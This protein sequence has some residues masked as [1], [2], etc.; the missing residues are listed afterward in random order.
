VK[1]PSG[2]AFHYLPLTS[3]DIRRELYVTS[4]GRGRYRPGDPYPIVKHPI[5]YDFAW[6]QGR[7]LSDLAV[8]FL[9]EGG[10]EYEDRTL[11]RI[12]WNAGEVLLLPSGT[13]HRYR[14]DPVRGWTERW[15]CL[16]GEY[17]H[18]L[19][20][21]GFLPRTA[22]L[23]KL[24]DPAAFLAGLRRIENGAQTNSLLV[25]ALAMEA[26]ALAVEGHEVS[27]R[28]LEPSATGHP[29]VDRALEF[30]WLNSHR[31]LSVQLI[32]LE[33]GVVRRTLERAFEEGHT[34]SVGAEVLTCR[35]QRAKLLLGESQM[36]VK[37]VGHATGFAG[38][39][40]LIRAFR[41][42][43]NQTPMEFR[44]STVRGAA[45]AVTEGLES[46]AFI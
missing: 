9:K 4:W 16:N 27:H 11:G 14:P 5:D 34:R 20:A 19:R 36:S 7:V 32:A 3:T 46:R 37:E 38:S 33:L 22:L 43:L 29:L 26:L 15:L 23:R 31:P 39:R 12:K 8:V 25:E 44:R 40:G 30:I 2:H 18:R 6:S 28:G 45:I 21:K 35:L 17:L 24:S 1:L 10:G 13:W 41:R 42:E